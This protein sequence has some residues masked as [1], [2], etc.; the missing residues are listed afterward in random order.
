MCYFRKIEY[1]ILPTKS[2]SVLRNCPGCGRKTHFINTRK[3]RVNAN[4]NKLDVWL[5]YQCEDCKHTFNLTVYERQK[6]SSIP[7]EEY[8]RFLDNDEALA[9]TYGKAIPLFRKNKAEID[10][11][12][13]HYDYVLLGEVEESDNIS[14]GQTI[15]TIQDPFGLKIRPEK[16]IAEVLGL[17]RSQVRKMLQ[18]EEIMLENVSPRSIYVRIQT[19]LP[20]NPANR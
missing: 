3:F 17:S 6:V 9:E 20:E 11:E 12:N 2:F 19:D 15:L 8:Q 7:R 4:G 14:E 1:E 10:L 13:L 18:R 16:Q 5:I